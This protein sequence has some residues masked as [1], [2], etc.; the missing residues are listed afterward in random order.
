MK[1]RLST[2]KGNN[3]L[4]GISIG[5]GSIRLVQFVQNN[6]K[7]HLIH[8]AY[9]E[10]DE[11]ADTD[12]KINV[13]QGLNEV[14]KE[15]TQKNAEV[16]CVVNCPKTS[17]AKIRLPLMPEDELGVAVRWGAKNYFPFP[18]DDAVLDFKVMDK[19]LDG[20]NLKLSLLVATTTRENIN[21]IIAFFNSSAV[22]QEQFM[23]YRLRAIIPTSLA[24]ENIFVHST[25]V[26]NE[27][28]AVIEMERAITEFNV[29][30]NGLL[31]FSR[32]LP[33]SGNDITQSITRALVTPNGKVEFTYQEAEQI[34]IKYGIPETNQ[35][36]LIEGKITPNQLLSM[37]RPKLELLVNEI[38]RSIE[39]YQ[40][41][42]GEKINKIILRGGQAQMKGLEQY[43][44]KELNAACKV[45]EIVDHVEILSGITNEVK[46]SPAHGLDLAIGAALNDP[47]GINFIPSKKRSASKGLLNRFI[48]AA[49]LV[50]VLALLGYMFM[51][52]SIRLKESK[53]KYESAMRDYQNLIPGMKA[54]RDEFLLTQFLMQ[55]PRWSDFLK[56]LSHQ[57][58]P[59]MHV[60][61]LAMQDNQVRLTGFILPIEDQDNEA[62]LAELMQNLQ[63]GICTTVGLI[64]AKKDTSDIHISQFEIICSVNQ[65]LVP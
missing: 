62:A 60:A 64:E 61:Q 63:D 29:Y 58:V 12:R 42:H 51:N 14:F 27:T 6:D 22:D 41:E 1:K 25:G 31:E 65:G 38:D 15:V 49:S 57:I 37:M 13:L 56:G 3:S 23:G 50:A 26:S 8:T 46:S 44:S 10:F 45:E 2:K 39:F 19:S 55:R 36:D 7:L 48:P 18:L 30:K 24:L 54:F 35:S 11:Y 40:G 28:F 47:H 5:S 32:K 52:V 33:F 21:P 9:T 34:K 43:L 53:G 17:L 16:V 59:N 4:I 20:E